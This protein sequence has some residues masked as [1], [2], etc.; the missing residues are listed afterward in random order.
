MPGLICRNR[1]EPGSP[2]NIASRIWRQWPVF[3]F[4]VP[5]LETIES[6]QKLPAWDHTV[7]IRLGE[8]AISRAQ[9]QATAMIASLL[10]PPGTMVTGIGIV[11]ELRNM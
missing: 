7:L 3:R 9:S 10:I 11:P 5:G 4:V 2:G 8:S 1:K 6:R